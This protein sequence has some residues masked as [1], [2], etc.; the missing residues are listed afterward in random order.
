MVPGQALESVEEFE[1]RRFLITA[2]VRP[3]AS[4]QHR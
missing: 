4:E 1:K 3:E 2:A